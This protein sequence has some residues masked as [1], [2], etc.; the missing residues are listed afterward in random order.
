MG[1]LLPL[2]GRESFQAVLASVQDGRSLSQATEQ[3][4]RG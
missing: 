2:N 1:G 4:L 3:F